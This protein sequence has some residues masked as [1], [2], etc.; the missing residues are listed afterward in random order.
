M[1]LK[2]VFQAIDRYLSRD[3]YLPFVVDVQNSRDQEALLERYCVGGNRRIWAGNYCATDELPRW[4]EILAILKEVAGVS[5]VTGITA[6]LKLQGE[7]K[8]RSSLRQLLNMSVAGRVVVITCQ[9]DRY[10]QFADPRLGR[11]ICILDSEKDP[12]PQ[13]VFTDNEKYL[14]PA[15]TAVMGVSKISSLLENK[16]A[17]TIYVVTKK[18]RDDFPQSLIHFSCL[19]SAYDLLVMRDSRTSALPRNTGTETQWAYALSQFEEQKNWD[20]VVEKHFGSV[21]ALE[22]AF[23][24][25]REFDENKKWLYFI[26]LKLFGAA[27]N[28][29]LSTAAN[30]ADKAVDLL[31]AVYRCLLQKDRRDADFWD[32]YEARKSALRRLDNTEELEEY[33]KIVFI[34]GKEAIYYLTDNTQRERETIVEYLARHGAQL[35]PEEL[36]E[37]LEHVYPALRNYLRPYRFEHELLNEYFQEYK[38]QK[39][40]NQVFPAFLERVEEQAVKREYNSLLPARSSLIDSLNKDG[41]KLYFMD[42]MGVEYLAYILSICAEFKLFTHI[43]VCRADLPTL[44]SVNKEFLE[45]FATAGCEIVTYKKLDEIKHHG[46]ENADLVKN[47]ERPLYLV[48]ELEVLRKVLEQVRNELASGKYQRVYMISDHGASRLA[49]LQNTENMLEM[50]EKG[51]H[52]GRCCPKS[53]CDLQPEHAADAGDYWALA[54]YDRFKGGRKADVEVHGGATLE[55]ICVPVIEITPSNQAV[56]IYL[57]SPEAQSAVPGDVPEVKV[58]FRKKMAL[59]IFATQVLRNVTIEVDGKAYTCE[60]LGGNMY[61][62]QMPDLKKAGTYYASVNSDGN[63]IAEKLPFKIKKEG[64][65]GNDVL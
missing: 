30:Q 64:L 31:G 12:L 35:P 53:D 32:C 56:E 63:L 16:T 14:P 8:L 57:L 38:Y 21:A 28:W 19:E 49:V 24:R 3:E 6:F 61:L 37:V 60:E 42:A 20:D 7:E 44:T 47:T 59:K 62:A 29:C 11:L 48:Q 26:A 39:V 46:E 25:Y 27:N 55:E 45:P 36:N 10:L 1:Q 51:Q 54:N 22:Y 5:I 9:C 58:S 17:D 41:A 23:A 50:K 33:C 40:F 15:C 43:K 52:S 18:R 34:K 13:I 2:E 4:D 65:T